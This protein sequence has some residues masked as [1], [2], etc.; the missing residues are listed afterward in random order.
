MSIT[1]APLRFALNSTGQTAVIPCAGQAYVA[2]GVSGIW[3][4]LLTFQVTYDGTTWVP[5][6]MIPYPNGTTALTTAGN[7]IWYQ[8]VVGQYGPAQAVR[9]L[10][11]RTSGTAIVYG[12]SSEDLSALS[13]LQST[14]SI[15]ANQ[16]GVFSATNVLTVTGATGHGWNLRTLV[17]SLVGPTGS[18]GTIQVWDGAS[19]PAGAT[20]IW[21]QDWYMAGGVIVVNVPLPVESALRPGGIFTRPGNA[22]IVNIPGVTTVRSTINAEIE[23]S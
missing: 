3:A 1:N 22:L 19:G 5:L 4:G 15:Y 13:A 23:P 10:F 21:Q 18:T 8:S 16:V 6:S 14:G 20:G 7:G 2:I 11:T 12:A 17:V 9:V